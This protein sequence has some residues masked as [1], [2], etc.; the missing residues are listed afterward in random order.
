MHVQY[1]VIGTCF[2]LTDVNR[3]VVAVVDPEAV[4]EPG[5]VLSVPAVDGNTLDG[6]CTLFNF[7]NYSFVEYCRMF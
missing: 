5:H 6:P 1:H 3:G 7:L 4:E 2:E